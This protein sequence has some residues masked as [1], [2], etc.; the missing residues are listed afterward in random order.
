MQNNI[1]NEI[2]EDVY[3][4]IKLILEDI[5][6]KCDSLSLEFISTISNDL[7]NKLKQLKKQSEEKE[8][9]LGKYDV[10]KQDLLQL[11]SKIKM[12]ETMNR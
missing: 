1:I 8:I 12:T 5:Y 2:F 9:Y 10:F 4:Q 6:S 11:S 3:N 7:K